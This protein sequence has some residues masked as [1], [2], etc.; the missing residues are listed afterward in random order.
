MLTEVRAG[1][2]TVRGISVGGI[3]TA[4]HVK[5]LDL[6]LDCGL[7]PRSF[8]GASTLL[9]S[10][11]HADHIGALTTLVGVR[12]L[13]GNRKLRIVLPAE[14]AADVRSVLDVVDRMQ[15]NPV[16]VELV[17]ASPGD[18]VRL[19]GDLHVHPFRTYHPVASLGYLVTRKVHKLRPEFRALAGPEIR[20]RR[21]AGED[22]FEQREHIELAYCT[23]TLVKALEDEPRVFE[24]RTLIVE[25]TFLDDRKSLDDAHKSCHIHLDELNAIADRFRNDCV[26]LMHF[27]QL[28]KPSEIPGIIDARCPAALRERVA[29]FAPRRSHWPG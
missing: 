9:L 8:A 21:R 17:P 28:Y 23:D 22:L 7:A 25:S 13:L 5:E 27:S 24:A 1:P 6:L 29:V 12:M 26:L 16:N 14:I 19:H 4:L 20:D 15:R 2:Y 11:G 18:V 3:Y 10:H